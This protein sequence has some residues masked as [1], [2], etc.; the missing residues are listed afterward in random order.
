MGAAREKYT[1][2]FEKRYIDY[3]QTKYLKELLT[4]RP[5]KPY[6]LVK[7]KQQRSNLTFWIKMNNN[8]QTTA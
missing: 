8:V 2:C 4:H 5:P 1:T 6:V 3:L 7:N